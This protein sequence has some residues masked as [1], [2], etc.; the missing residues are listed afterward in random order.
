MRIARILCALPVLAVARLLLRYRGFTK[1]VRC[2]SASAVKAKQGAVLANARKWAAAVESAARRIP[3]TA[4]LPQALALHWLL[5]RIGCRSEIALGARSDNAITA[6]AWV[7]V[8]GE[9]VL[10]ATEE[11]FNR[12]AAIRDGACGSVQP[13]QRFFDTRRDGV[14]TLETR[15]EAQFE[16]GHR[17]R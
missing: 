4:C 14:E 3:G 17:R 11:R 2:F 16:H 7:E 1:A 12:F 15:S 5:A 9:V 8:D 6:H 13:G 10:G